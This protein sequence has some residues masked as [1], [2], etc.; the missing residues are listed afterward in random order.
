MGKVEN[1]ADMASQQETEFPIEQLRNGDDREF[2]ISSSMEIQ[3]IL[4]NIANLGTRICIHYGDATHSVMTTLLG[5]NQHA[6]WLD[7]RQ[8]PQEHAQL[9]HGGTIT[10]V[11]M[12]QHVKI[13]FESRNFVNGLLGNKKA[14]YLEHPDSLLRIQRREFFRSAIPPTGQASCI[15]P[16]QREGT[17]AQA[18]LRATPLMDISGGG[19][20]LLCDGDDAALLPNRT[21]TDCQISLPDADPL[22][23]TLEVRNSASFTASDN[24]VYKRV[25]CRFVSLN[26]Q[27][28]IL[29]QRHITR[30]QG[31]NVAR[32]HVSR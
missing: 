25:G 27:T 10:F 20:R 7:A 26:K 28:D 31:E 16:I 15:I 6:M 17:D 29:L 22:T 23:V 12:H 32:R 21:F 9:L 30:L 4:Q 14:F 11:S 5:I 24:E 8:F 1:F 13:Q 18:T 19:I 3:S 2:R